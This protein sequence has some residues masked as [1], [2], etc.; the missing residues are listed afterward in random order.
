MR[1]RIF[2]QMLPIAILIVAG[3]ATAQFRRILQR[4]EG[5][6]KFGHQD[7]FFMTKHSNDAEQEEEA[8]SKETGAIYGKILDDSGQPVYVMQ[9]VLIPV[10]KAKGGEEERWQAT[11]MD[12]TNKDG[13]Y[14]F[15]RLPAGEYFLSAGADSAP[16]GRHPFAAIYYPGASKE[17]FSE[18]IR[19]VSSMRVELRTL[20]LQRLQTASIKI[21][22]R[23]QDGTPV[24]WSNLLFYNPRFPQQGVIG[25][26]APGVKDGEGEFT[27]PIG[28][29]YYA[30]AVV[31]CDA[32]S[33]IASVES[34]P[35]QKIRID[36]GHI[37]ED[38]TFVIPSEACK[39]W[40]SS[41]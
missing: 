8:E 9:V 28:F 10:A 31:N 4:H 7:G 20:R 3:L 26:E 17:K 29:E 40:I 6:D 38:L 12:W 16:T 19:V 39:I 2:H 41:K 24:K 25:D 11:L 21:H 1:T 35:V 5:T 13:I 33:K 27:A 37:P 18:P 23:W 22:V 15:S 34:R 14:E 32:G 36:R 30:R